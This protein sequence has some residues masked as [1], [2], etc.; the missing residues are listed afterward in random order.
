VPQKAS[1]ID[2]RR[3][4]ALWAFNRLR[5]DALVMLMNDLVR[6][7]SDGLNEEQCDHVK[8]VLAQV[9]NCAT[10]LPD[11]SAIRK[12]IWREFQRFEDIYASWNDPKGN[13]ASAQDHRKKELRNLRKCRH[14]L[15][16]RTR[17]NLH[18]LEDNLDL[19]IVD[20]AYGSLEDLIKLA[21]KY[22]VTFRKLLS[23]LRKA[24]T[25]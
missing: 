16:R 13:Y 20:A 25:K 21:P 23:D 9:S 3:G 11:G 24:R 22:F 12:A 1:A 17:K 6:A 5:S 7:Q 14:K 10:A 19:A 8:I 15:S 4:T 2:N 18:I